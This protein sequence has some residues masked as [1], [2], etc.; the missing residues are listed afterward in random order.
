MAGYSQLQI[1]VVHDSQEYL[2]EFQWVCQIDKY[3]NAKSATKLSPEFFKVTGYL[4]NKLVN[5]LGLE[6]M[7]TRR[8]EVFDPLN[9]VD[10]TA[11]GF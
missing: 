6:K 3:D 9:L 7:L 11:M 5:S 2:I 4:T 1:Q 8:P 10:F